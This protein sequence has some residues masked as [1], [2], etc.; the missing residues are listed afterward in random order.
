MT[1]PPGSRTR[2][3]ASVTG[4]KKA[5]RAAAQDKAG[6][7]KA[8]DEM[9]GMFDRIL[10]NREGYFEG[11]FGEKGLAGLFR[12]F[13]VAVLVLAAL[14]GVA[15]GAAS[16]RM[17]FWHGVEQVISSG[18]KVPLLYLLSLAVCFPVLYFV[19][20][21]LGSRLSFLQTLVLIL[22]ALVLNCILLAG[23]APIVLF[24]TFTD[25]SYEFIKL[26]HVVIFVFSGAWAMQ[27]LW[28]GLTAMCE[29][30]NLYPKQAVRIL[31]V[32]ILV[33]GFVG[34]QMA[35]SLRPF[36]G[37]PDRKFQVI[38]TTQDGNFY[39]MIWRSIV[40]LGRDD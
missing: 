40:Q 11:I 31:Q 10:R 26:L 22:M 7:G 2:A 37:S 23:C 1:P 9:L 3:R 35:W 39:Q 19:I 38:R 34:T 29:K 12:R 20:V 6:T 33:Y 14:Y 4:G 15:M 24:F 17:G 27:A 25:S 30:W 16:F 21:L 5:E 28:H 13:L 36:V 32:W 8:S 18:I